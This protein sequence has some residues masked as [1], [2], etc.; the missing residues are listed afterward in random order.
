MHT[1]PPGAVDMDAGAGTE[2][3]ARG[4]EGAADDCGVRGGELEDGGAVAREGGGEG[5]DG[6]RVGRGGG[7]VERCD[8]VEAHPGEGGPSSGGRRRRE[9]GWLILVC[10]GRTVLVVSVVGVVISMFSI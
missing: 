10:C 9:D 6:A 7:A 2:E 1:V 4:L 3:G 8:V 5:V